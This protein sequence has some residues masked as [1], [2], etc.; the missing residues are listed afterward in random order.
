MLQANDV[1]TWYGTSYVLQGTS[2]EVP[3]SQCTAVLGRNGVGKT[4]LVRT[5]CGFTPPGR[6]EVRLRGERI[7]AMP[8]HRIVRQGLA[9]VPQGR[10][11]FKN[12]SVEENL[13]VAAVDRARVAEVWERFPRLH[14]RRSSVAGRLSGGE[15]QML[16]IG[17]AL[18]TDPTVLVLDEPTEGLA[19]AIT[20][21]LLGMLQELKRSGVSLLLTEQSVGFALALADTAYVMSSR[22]QIAYAGTAAALAADASVQEKH[23]GVAV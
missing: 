6:G 20:E 5:I 10:R 19:P 4:T 9:V 3:E 7:D 22:G 12:L 16:A 17:R 21:S 23:L 14:E 8:A 13:Q 15:Q 1:H 11:V 2:I 18:V